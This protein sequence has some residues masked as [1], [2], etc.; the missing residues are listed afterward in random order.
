MKTKFEF[1]S[2]T[3]YSLHNDRIVEVSNKSEEVVSFSYN[4]DN[5]ADLFI[6]CLHSMQL[7]FNDRSPPNGKNN[8]LITISYRKILQRKKQSFSLLKL[9]LLSIFFICACCPSSIIL[10]GFQGLGKSPFIF[11]CPFLFYLSGDFSI[12]LTLHLLCGKLTR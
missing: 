2:T 5:F 1:Q 6:G 8:N 12:L 10:Q 9:S 3:V 11:F 7:F 4:V